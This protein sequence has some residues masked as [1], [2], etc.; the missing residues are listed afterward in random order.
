[1]KTIRKTT[2]T[3]STWLGR[4]GVCTVHQ[5]TKNRDGLRIVVM[6]FEDEKKATVQILENDARA[7]N[8]IVHAKTEVPSSSV[9]AA[10]QKM[11]AQ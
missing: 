7:T 4:K 8:F 1:M 2:A 10:I 5:L 11:L 9:D 6:Q 3:K